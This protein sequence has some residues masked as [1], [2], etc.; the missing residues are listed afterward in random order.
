MSLTGLLVFSLAYA[1]AVA[2]PGPGI[3]AVVAQVLG[4]GLR[5]AP[6]YVLGILT[7]DLIL[8]AAAALGLAAV[9]QA[10]V[11]VFTLIKWAGVLYLLHH[12][13]L[14]PG[15]VL[16]GGSAGAIPAPDAACASWRGGRLNARSAP[17]QAEVRAR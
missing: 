8:F 15:G 4:R 12:L 10:Y 11:G 1:L 2:S 17:R 3:A 16:G 14:A 9:A 6:A 13:D 5:A 7:G